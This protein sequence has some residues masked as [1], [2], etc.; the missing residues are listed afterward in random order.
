MSQPEKSG[1]DKAEYGRIGSMPQAESKHQIRDIEGGKVAMQRVVGQIVDRNCY[2]KD[3]YP[4]LD[5]VGD[6]TAACDA[7]NETDAG[8]DQGIQAKL[9]GREG[10]L[11]QA[12]GK[13]EQCRLQVTTRECNKDNDEQD[14]I[15]DDVCYLYVM[16]PCSLQYE[17][18]TQQQNMAYRAQHD[19]FLAFTPINR[20]P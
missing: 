19:E 10:V 12:D 16:N 1:D 17:G 20:Q 5:R 3:R 8:V 9:C 6:E 13:T 14:K 7:N 2:S 15:G 18:Q 4:N 11:T